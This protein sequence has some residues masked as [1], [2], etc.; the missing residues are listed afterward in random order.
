M[1][2]FDGKRQQDVV[3]EVPFVHRLRFTTDV[4]RE[5]EQVLVELLQPSADDS[6][7]VQFWVDENVAYHIPELPALITAF[8]HRHRDRIRWVGEIQQVPGGEQVKNDIRILER[9]LTTLHAADLDR[10]SY[11]VAIGGGAVLDAVG[12]AAAIAHRGIR[13]VRLPTTTLAQADSGIGVKNSVNLFEK[14]NWV[15]TFAVPWGVVNDASMLESL[16]D[17]DFRCGFSEAVKVSL[18]KSVEMFDRLHQ[19]ADAVGRRERKAAE[20]MIR[21]SAQL[22]L[23]ILPRAAIRSRPGKPAHSI[24]DT[25]PP[26]GWKPCPI[27]NCAMEKRW[28][29]GWR[30][31]RSILPWS[32]GW[33]PRRPIACWS[34]SGGWGSAYPTPCWRIRAPSSP[35]WR[36]FANTWED[37]SP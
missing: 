24:S 13:L 29:L 3:F 27:S 18:L 21:W 33:G 25:G 10:H 9:I 12:F 15:G 22:H 19:M 36:S 34:V 11:V 23:T 5:D 17:R 28:P 1:A 4:L 8:C 16:S 14:K 37:G 26:T 31:T 6:P 2:C 20:E 35:G 30:L 7:R 32:M